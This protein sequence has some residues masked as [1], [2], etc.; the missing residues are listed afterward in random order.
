MTTIS[1]LSLK[2]KRV[3]KACSIVLFGLLLSGPILNA[4]H[5]L[6][7]GEVLYTGES[8]VSQNGKYS[9]SLQSDGNLVVYR[10]GAAAV[11]HTN[12]HNQGH[13]GNRK[14]TL[15]EDHN[16]VLYNSNDNGFVWSSGS[17]NKGHANMAFLVMQD[18]GNAVLYCGDEPIWCAWVYPEDS[19]WDTIKKDVKNLVKDA[20]TVAPIVLAPLGA[21]IYVM[22]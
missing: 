17:Q 15:Q 21:P 19:R 18:D 10:D 4:K 6:Q 22:P 5:I 7:Q 9:L 13:A 20:G 16:L 2:L 14:L 8:L 12:S 3:L 1:N 11:W